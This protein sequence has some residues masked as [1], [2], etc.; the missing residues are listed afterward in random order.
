MPSPFLK[1]RSKL[2]DRLQSKFQSRFAKNL[3]WLGIAEL[4]G[5]IFRLAVTVTMARV[6]IPTDY[7]MVSAIYTVF[8]F[9]N[10]FSLNNAMISKI[11]QVDEEHLEETCNTAYWMSW[12][13]TIALT[14]L[15]IG[16]APAIAAF[17]KEPT[18]LWPLIVLSLI[19]WA[20]PFSIVEEGLIQRQN[21]LDF[22]SKQFL[23]QAIL[24][25]LTILLTLPFGFGVWGVVA[26]MIVPSPLWC[27]AYAREV[28]WKPSRPSFSQFKPLFN[29]ATQASGIEWLNQFKLNI[30]Y[31]I[32]VQFLGP[33][34][35]GQYFFAFNAGLGISQS[36][37]YSLSSAFYPNFCEAR[38]DRDLLKSRFLKSVKTIGIV[39]IPLVI[40]QTSLASVY[41]PLIF[42]Q[43]WNDAIPV[44]RIICCSAIPIA[45]GYLASDFLK[46]LDRMVIDIVWNIIFVA[47]LGGVL[48]GIVQTAGGN[49]SAIALGVLGT[50]LLLM[51]GFCVWVYR[52]SFARTA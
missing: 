32:V 34:A 13:I 7:A 31:L 28:R 3:G 22:Q 10:S 38:S 12:V 51:P 8:A 41:V 14:L 23:I 4:V 5:R 44:L 42:G 47:V 16:L 35:L 46:A 39:V 48:F 2:P 49:L 52:R 43:K 36:V 25:N 18:L 45:F 50:Y 21:R 19:Y 33:A 6:F 37:L 40:V 27:W 24:G 1:L 30:D 29:F 9:G 26:S 20:M 11:V 17:Y 15:Q